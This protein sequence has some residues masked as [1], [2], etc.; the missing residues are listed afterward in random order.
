VSVNLLEILKVLGNRQLGAKSMLDQNRTPI[1]LQSRKTSRIQVSS[2]KKRLMENLRINLETK[3]RINS[4]TVSRKL[5][6]SDLTSIALSKF[7]KFKNMDAMNR[8]RPLN[9]NSIIAS[10]DYI[11]LHES[12]ID[13]ENSTIGDTS[14]KNLSTIEDR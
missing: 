12:S 8:Y 14:N 7:L 10:K 3:L 4:P 11:N 2:S 9:N 6:N 1:S 13:V 5:F